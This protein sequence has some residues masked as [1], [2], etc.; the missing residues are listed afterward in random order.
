MERKIM[1]IENRASQIDL[2]NK[3][4][5]FMPFVD[6]ETV[7]GTV[8][9]IIDG[10]QSIRHRSGEVVYPYSLSPKEIR[11][12]RELVRRKSGNLIFRLGDFTP[13]R[14]EDGMGTVISI[15]EKGRR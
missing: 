8:R 9:A 10:M 14:L 1:T 3:R 12:V 13:I 15:K 11:D 5:D 7:K 4:S 6:S 2:K